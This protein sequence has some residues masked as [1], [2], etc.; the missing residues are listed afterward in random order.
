MQGLVKPKAR[1]PQ[2]ASNLNG[3][4]KKQTAPGLVPY[5][6]E[7]SNSSSSDSDVDYDRVVEQFS[8]TPAG[9]AGNPIPKITDNSQLKTGD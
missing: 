7:D 8:M 1:V 6:A 9:D 5:T 4:C 3:I 2:D